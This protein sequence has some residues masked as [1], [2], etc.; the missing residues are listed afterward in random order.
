MYSEYNTNTNF[1]YMKIVSPSTA[2]NWNRYIQKIDCV[3]H[4]YYFFLYLVKK[5][6]NLKR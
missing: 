4:L 5:V 6:E 1:Y 3:K 2:N